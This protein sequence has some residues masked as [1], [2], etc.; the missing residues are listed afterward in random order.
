MSAQ[1]ASAT[2]DGAH[3]SVHP[4]IPGAPWYAALLIAVTATAIGY[5]IDAGH[6]ELTHVFAGFY[7]AGCVA[8]VLAVRQDGIF[9]TIIQP[10]LILFCAVPGAY[11]LFHDAKIGRLKDLLINCGYPLIERFPLMLGTAG[12]VLAI[13]LARWY[14]GNAQGTKATSTSTDSAG[15]T[16]V[17]V[18][19]FFNSIGAKLQ[20]A[21][22]PD[23]D[24]TD[25]ATESRRGRTSGS[26][27]RTRRTARDGR[28]STRSRSRHARPSLDDESVERPERPRRSTRRNAAAARDYD[29][30]PPRRSRRRPRPE[31]DPDLRGQTPR[32]PRREPR[33]RRNPYERPYDRPAPRGSRFDGFEPYGDRYEESREPYE[34]RRRRPPSTGS[35]GTHHPISQVRYR[36]GTQ[37]QPREPHTERRSRSRTP[38]RAHG[39]PAAESW[40]YDV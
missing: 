12:A 10:P 18:K 37:D 27:A 20:S 9:T 4:N 8:A 31:G 25:E 5:G 13:G 24:D 26:S 36:G 16:G 33:T 29:A 11:W 28:S 19:S 40:E 15:A 1:R 2:V 30:E 34:P 35:G 32:E 21:L 23:A 22:Q 7:I 3:R 38:G 39:R 6:K 14:F 17:H